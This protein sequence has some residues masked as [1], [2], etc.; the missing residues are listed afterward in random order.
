MTRAIWGLKS[1]FGNI[2]N[3]FA[4]G[5]NV[6]RIS[7]LEAHFSNHFGQY[8]QKSGDIG[9]LFI[10]ERD[11]DWASCFLSPLTYEGLLDE[12]FGISCGT[13]EFGP[14]VEMNKESFRRGKLSQ[15]FY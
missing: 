11:V 12:T 10:F 4:I 1:I 8:K 13:V 2:P 7:K 3:V 6:Q 14:E 15:M 5:K 9:S